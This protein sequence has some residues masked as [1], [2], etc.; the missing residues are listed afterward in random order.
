MKAE[1]SNPKGTYQWIFESTLR[2]AL[3]QI[4]HVRTRCA[5]KIIVYTIFFQAKTLIFHFRLEKIFK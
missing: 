5:A 2:A 4:F 3:I 1:K